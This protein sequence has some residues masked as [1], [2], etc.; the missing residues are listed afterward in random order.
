MRRTTRAAALTAA[1]CVGGGLLSPPAQAGDGARQYRITITVKAPGQPL[2]PPLVATH[3]RSVDVFE[4]GDRA[5][6]G[7]REIAENGNLAPLQARLEG[8]R[9]VADV[10]ASDEPLVGAGL[11]GA[12]MFDRSGTFRISGSRGAKYLSWVSML[13]CTNDGFTGVD[14]LRLPKRVGD[15]AFARTAGY[16]AGTEVNTED[17]ADNVP[18]C[19]GLTLPAPVEPG[20]GTSDPAL[21]EGGVITHHDGIMGGVDL[22]P[23]LHGWDTA[24][25]VAKIKVVRVR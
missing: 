17:F 7:V 4:V 13:V 19:Q 8:S 3:R 14:A 23:A 24:A 15:S 9:R 25:P 10:F 22:D 20:S 16:D 11:P 21:A 1:V 18:P 12:A 6:P 2:T 5:R